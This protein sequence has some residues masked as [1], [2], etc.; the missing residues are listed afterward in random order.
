MLTFQCWHCGKG[1]LVVLSVSSWDV[2]KGAET[3]GSIVHEQPQFDKTHDPTV[4]G[5]CNHNLMIWSH[6]LF[7]KFFETS[8]LWRW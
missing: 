8:H 1:M 6:G 3:R 4:Y 2:K 5:M 7:Y